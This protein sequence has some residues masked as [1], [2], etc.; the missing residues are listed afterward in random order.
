MEA[1]ISNA[2]NLLKTNRLAKILEIIVVFAP[3]LLIFNI[4]NDMADSPVM[5]MAIIWVANVTMLLLVWCGMKL[6]GDGFSDFGINFKRIR[7]KNALRTIGLSLLVCFCA[8]LAYV[9]GTIIMVNFSGVP[10]PADMSNYQYLQNNFFI[11]TLTLL[12]VYIVSSFGEEVIYRAFLINRFM[13]LGLDTKKGRILAAVL[14]AAIFGLVHFQWGATGVVATGFM[15][16]VMGLFYLK[17][18]DNLW[19]LVLAH[20]Y[21]D[22]MLLVPLFLGGN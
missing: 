5:K 15:G 1:I 2:G 3:G 19:I 22:T 18:K 8:G 16:L 6:R 20:A 12:G 11:F 10:E 13:E 9:L 14:S 7:L 21:L 4:I 17:F